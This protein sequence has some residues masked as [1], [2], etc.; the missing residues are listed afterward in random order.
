MKGLTFLQFIIEIIFCINL[1]CSKL[2][3]YVLRRLANLIGSTKQRLYFSRDDGRFLH[4]MM[5]LKAVLFRFH[6]LPY[7]SRYQHPLSTT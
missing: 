6:V 7:R 2:H 1:S 3:L 4:D 5:C